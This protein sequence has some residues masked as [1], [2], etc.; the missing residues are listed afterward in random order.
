MLDVSNATS[1]AFIVIPLPAPTFTVTSP[2]LPPPV[3]PDPAVTPD[4]SPTSASSTAIL[5]DSDADSAVKDPVIDASVRLLIRLLFGPNEPLI[6]EAALDP[7]VPL[8]IFVS[9]SPLNT[10]LIVAAVILCL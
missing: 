4:I 1:S 8:K 9:V 6:S 10:E 7:N 3:K 2:E 5:D